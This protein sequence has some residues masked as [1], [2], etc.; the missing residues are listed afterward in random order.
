MKP[1]GL[2]S[3]LAISLSL[4]F[5]TAAPAHAAEESGVEFE[6]SSPSADYLVVSMLQ[7]CA[8]LKQRQSSCRAP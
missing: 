1:V 4:A 6:L 8:I 5:A 3:A 2:A 7:N